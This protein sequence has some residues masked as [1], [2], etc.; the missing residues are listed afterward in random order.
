[1]R[2]CLSGCSR[3]S[4]EDVGMLKQPDESVQ[5]VW[6]VV[7]TLLPSAGAPCGFR[8][9][10]ISEN[11]HLKSFFFWGGGGCKEEVCS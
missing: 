4:A 2:I 1:M 8:L 7:L 5:E 9:K 3:N 11:F 6:A 10:H